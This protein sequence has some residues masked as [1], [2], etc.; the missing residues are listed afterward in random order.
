MRRAEGDELVCEADVAAAGTGVV[1]F[2]HGAG[3]EVRHVFCGHGLLGGL[4]GEVFDGCLL[5]G[6]DLGG[7]CVFL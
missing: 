4:L 1:G 2:G 3:E 6:C 7:V 5:H